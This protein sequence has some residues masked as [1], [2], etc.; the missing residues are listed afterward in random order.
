MLFD[1]GLSAALLKAGDVFLMKT[2]KPRE[3]VAVRDHVCP[4]RTRMRL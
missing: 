4:P 1:T 3:L 2:G